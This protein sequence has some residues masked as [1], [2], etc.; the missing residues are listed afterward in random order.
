[1]VLLIILGIV[2]I[3]TLLS[4]LVEELGLAVLVILIVIAVWW[5]GRAW[6]GWA[7]T[8]QQVCLDRTSP[9]GV[10]RRSPGLAE[11]NWWRSA[12]LLVTLYVIGI[13]SGPIVGFVLLFVTP[14]EPRWIDLIGSAIY[15][16]VLPFV[17]ISATLLFF[18]LKARGSR[19]P[20]PVADAALSTA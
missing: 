16:L 14:L 9:I 10:I 5:V 1:V 11:G 19:A 18:D 2:G 8:S 6:V 13:S 7:L 4:S 3:T 17:A 15:V 20:E 12:I